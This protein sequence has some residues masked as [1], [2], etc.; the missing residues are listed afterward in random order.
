MCEKRNQ[1]GYNPLLSLCTVEKQLLLLIW[2]RDVGGPAELIDCHTAPS[3]LSLPLLSLFYVAFP[4]IYVFFLAHTQYTSYKAYRN[5]C[6]LC[7]LQFIY[8]ANVLFVGLVRSLAVGLIKQSCCWWPV[9][10]WAAIF[11]T[12]YGGNS[13]AALSGRTSLFYSETGAN[14]VF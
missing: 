9:S 7:C 13:G 12:N 10:H 11:W 8:T 5:R 6:F 2:D 3:T 14:W 4:F 1:N